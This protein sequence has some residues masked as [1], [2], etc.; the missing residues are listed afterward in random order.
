[1]TRP[2][3][4]TNEPEPP[5]LKRTDDFCTCSSQAAVGSKL[6]FS[7]SSL[8]GGLLNSHMPSSEY[9]VLEANMDSTIPRNKDRRIPVMNHSFT[10]M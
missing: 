2:S 5:Q 8:R 7:L 10:S 1:M 3:A 4:E 9:V 6:Y